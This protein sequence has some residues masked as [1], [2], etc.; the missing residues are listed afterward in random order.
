M[1]EM[2]DKQGIVSKANWRKWLKA[3]L[4]RGETHTA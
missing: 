4:D 2:I 3:G 1:I